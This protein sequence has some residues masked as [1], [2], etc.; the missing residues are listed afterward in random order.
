MTK[1]HTK[2]ALFSSVI[3]LILC[4]AMLAGTTFAWFTDN[5]TSGVNQI[6]AGNLDVEL[7][8]GKRSPTNKVSDQT[9]LF[10]DVN[11][12]EIDLWE[13]GVVAYTNMKVVNAGTLALKYDLFINA[14][15][16][17]ATSEGGHKLSEVLKVAMIKGGVVGTTREAVLAEA[18]SANAIEL[19][20][21]KESGTLYPKD[22]TLGSTVSDIY[23]IIVFWAPNDNATDNLYNMNNGQTTTDKL[24]LHI[25]LGVSL[26][27]TQVEAESDSFGNDYDASAAVGVTTA[28]ELEAALAEGGSI[29]L[30]NDIALD[31]TIVIPA[32]TT[33]ALNL[34]EK[35]ISANHHKNN[36]AVIKNEGN[37]TLIGGT[38]K[39]TGDNGGSAVQ[40]NG[41]MTIN[42]TTLNGAPNAGG[43][44]PSYTV[45]NT[46]TLE[47]NN[48][49]ITSFHGAVASYDD[50]AVVTLNNTDI[51]MSG[52]PGFTSHGI[53][54]YDN[55]VVI[56]NGGN[57][58]NNAADQNATGASVI[59]GAVT[60]N[61]GNFTGRIENYDGTPVIKGGT[62]NQ[63]PSRFVVNGYKVVDNGDGT[64]TVTMAEATLEEL[65]AAGSTVNLP[66]GDYT[67]PEPNL[68]GKSLT[69]T[70]TKDT[71]I[72]LTAVDARD[73]FVTG[74]NI[75]F[76]GVTLNFGN[77][78]YMGL[79]NTAS[80]TYKNCTINGLQFLYG[81]NVTFEN[82]DLNSNGAEHCV[83]TYGAKNVS[84]TDCDFTYGDRGINCYS[85]N[86]IT[87]G[88]QT[89]NFTNC[90]F[91]TENTAS[92]GA[93]E[94]NSMYFSKG[95]DVN[96]NDCT[97]PAYGEMV[98][99]SPWD[100]TKGAKTMITVDGKVIATTA[101]QLA[102]VVAKGATEIYLAD[103]EYNVENCGGK[104]LT[105]NGSKDAVIK[106]YN[107]G[108]DG[109]D[110]G[111]DSS[112]V[113]FNGVTINTTANT[114]NYKGY[115]RM[116]ATFNDCEFFG[117]YTSNMVQSF[118]NCT[119]DFNNGYF[120]TWGANSV[121][122][123][124]CTFNG[125]SKTIL[126]HG[127]ASTVITINN[128]NFAATEKG[129][130]GSG[131]HTAVVEIDPVGTN[132]YTINFTGDNSKTDNYAGWTRVKDT[133]TGHTINGV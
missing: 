6:K 61:S 37:L 125:N 9:K 12:E 14:T 66:A 60:V 96:L 91:A 8:H 3:A 1:K 101:E 129:Y 13:P 75:V 62:F 127:G 29:Y 15:N 52:I 110:Y 113:T 70:G 49:K 118:N 43:S 131:D 117:A 28:A 133:S 63:D 106:L 30:G 79:A 47:I 11:G 111:F 107:E 85:D 7:Y 124:G 120:W 82:C 18:E 39:S 108:E 40:N 35:T 74:A 93:V 102:G 132:T 34:N 67:M 38:V 71:V 65:F 104:T 95:I 80:L 112:A 83:W 27:A 72:D 64:Y 115:A 69:V 121:T 68:Q 41:T 84:F 73:Q 24:P 2:K 126:A 45:N 123:D 17:N 90:T 36:G 88:L 22:S 53:Y 98:Y 21:F 58:A 76:D 33:V 97:A 87:G 103:G 116:T 5:V 86:D 50:G 23:G 4:F 59:N 19:S 54:T 109:C 99:V 44:W 128:C 105:I 89:V 25:D 10:T 100:S 94:I 31:K 16:E 42:G 122:F 130:T 51:D 20:N 92:E 26:L 57:I 77:L 56:V 46:G 114:G 32:G 55:G 78:N 48:A 119:F 81:E